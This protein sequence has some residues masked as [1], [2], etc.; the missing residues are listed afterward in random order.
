MRNRILAISTAVLFVFGVNASA[1]SMTSTAELKLACETSLN[2]VVAINVPTQI[3]SGPQAPL[4]ENVNTKCTLVLGSLVSFEASQVS[5]TFAGPLRIQGGNESH[6]LFIE[7]EF[8]APSIVST[9]TSKS[10]FQVERSLLRATAGNIAINTGSEGT[11]TVHGP[12]LGG[13][14]IATGA[15]NMSGGSKFYAGLTD[16]GVSAGAGFNVNMTGNE[17]YFVSVTSSIEA[18]NG[19]INVTGSGEKNFAEFKFNSLAASPRGVNV[20][21][22]GN[23]SE[24]LAN[25]YTFNAGTGLI[26]RT[27]GN[28]GKVTADNGMISA[29]GSVFVQAST[30]GL[31]GT[32][33][34]SKTTLNAGGSARIETGARGNTEVLDSSLNA[35]SLVRI[36]TGAGGNCK[37]QN[38]IITALTQQV[39]Q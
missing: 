23:E 14:L 28:K 26:L 32:A 7:S 9:T 34:V 15:I 39:C 17:A 8:N 18:A 29:N 31:E 6:V 21:L 3:T 36:A 16:A 13:N 11:V 19:A 27:G 24:I 10:L 22:N 12:L 35:N 25:Q 20:R 4:T 5:M 30:A 37:S 1:Q 38:N 33:L 2:N